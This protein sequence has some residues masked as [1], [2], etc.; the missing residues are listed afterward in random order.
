MLTFVK[1]E[2][3]VEFRPEISRMVF[4]ECGKG[5]KDGSESM[6]KYRGHSVLAGAVTAALYGISILNFQF[7]RRGRGLLQTRGFG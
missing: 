5:L 2:K 6:R 7:P 1:Y 3:H 4:A